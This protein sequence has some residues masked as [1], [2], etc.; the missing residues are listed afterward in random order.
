MAQPTVRTA[1]DQSLDVHREGLSQIAFDLK[2][3]LNNFTNLD[4]MLAESGVLSDVLSHYNGEVQLHYHGPLHVY[5]VVEPDGKLT[6]TTAAPPPFSHTAADLETIVANVQFIVDGQA[7]RSPE[8]W[9]NR[10]AVVAVL[11]PGDG[12][13]YRSTL[14][15]NPSPQLAILQAWA[16]NGDR[17]PVIAQTEMILLLRSVFEDC[18]P[19]HPQLLANVRKLK[20]T[21]ASEVNSEVQKGKVSL[22]KSDVREM[23]GM[24]LIPDVITFKVPVFDAATLKAEASVRVCVDPDPDKEAFRLVVIPGQIEKAFTDGETWLSAKL[25]ELLAAGVPLYHGTP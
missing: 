23:S 15:L 6:R 14:T 18:T 5:Y 16:T 1:I 22:N 11:D 25:T 10:R 13:K 20:T 12:G 4:D 21:R 9:F 3:L 24:D 8:V 19:S 2:A 17:R 7:G